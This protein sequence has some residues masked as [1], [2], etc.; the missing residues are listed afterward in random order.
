MAD[1]N[2]PES[3]PC[4]RCGSAMAAASPR[5]ICRFCRPGPDYPS[6]ANGI[7]AILEEAAAATARLRAAYPG[8]FGTFQSER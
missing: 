8:D 5:T 4:E 1:T 3:K 6:T 2:F 7:D